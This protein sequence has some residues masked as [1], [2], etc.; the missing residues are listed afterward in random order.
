MKSHH[1][2]IL[3]FYL[4][5]HWVKHSTVTWEADEFGS[6]SPSGK[7]TEDLEIVVP[8]SSSRAT[9]SNQMED[10]GRVTI[11]CENTA[12]ALLEVNIY[13]WVSSVLHVGCA[14]WAKGPKIIGFID[15][16]LPEIFKFPS[17]CG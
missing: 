4:L 10:S 15:F 5:Y 9:G 11:T 2:D 1:F 14:E 17:H 6:Q 8:A 13:S 16:N 7:V 12:P 3:Y